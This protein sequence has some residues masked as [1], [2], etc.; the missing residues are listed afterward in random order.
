VYVEEVFV[1][2]VH[3]ENGETEL[4]HRTTEPVI[5]SKV[6]WLLVLPEQIVVPPVTVPPTEIGLTVTVIPLASLPVQPLF[7]KQRTFTL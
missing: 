4:S 1:I 3:A 7:S 6:N 5:P 2:A